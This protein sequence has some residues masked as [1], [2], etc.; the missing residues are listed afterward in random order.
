MDWIHVVQN[1]DKWRAVVSTVMNLKVKTTQHKPEVKSLDF[2]CN[3]MG[4]SVLI[5]ND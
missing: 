5:F 3:A 2:L 1:K 4:P